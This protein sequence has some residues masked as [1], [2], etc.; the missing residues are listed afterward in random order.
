MKQAV[1]I[2]IGGLLLLTAACRKSNFIGEELLPDEDF[3]NSERV[4]TF[5][6]VTYTDLNDSVVT[7]QN[8]FYALGSLTSETYGKSMAGIYTQVK[9]PTNNLYFGESPVVDSVVVTLDYAGYYGDTT[10]THSVNVYRMYERMQPGRLYYSDKKFHVLPVA[11]GHKTNFRANLKDSV[12]LA[13]SSVFEPHLRIK[14]FDGF[15]QNIV[16]LDSTYLENDTSFQDFLQGIYIEPD[17]LLAG[18][19]K[20]TMYFDMSSSLSGLRIYYHNTEADSLSITFPFTGIKTNYFTHTYPAASPIANAL[21][22][23][24]TTNGDAF[25]YVQGFDG[26]R[27]IVKFPTIKNLE[28]VSINKAELI[29]T[30]T[31]TDGRMYAPPPKIQLLQLDSTGHNFYYLALYS[32][33]TYSSIVDDNFGLSDIGGTIVKDET[34]PGRVVYQYK[35][36]I[37]QHIQEILE[38]SVDNYGFALVCQPGNRIP[39]AVTL[40]GAGSDRINYKPYLSITY[41]TINK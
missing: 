15:G 23:P 25:T 5:K 14:L 4:D 13:D 40:G 3:L 29:L 33:E 22:A 10:A 36:I 19:S 34:Q 17:T 20:G 1:F 41:T 28:D 2:F 27:T 6:I 16:G 21:A 32:I 9:L 18:H 37:T 39:N 38:G 31:T 12:M 8:I 7:S 35:Y 30:A 24:D 26:V 11:I